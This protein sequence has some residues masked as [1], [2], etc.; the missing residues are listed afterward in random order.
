[1]T[2]F[3]VS[4]VRDEADIIAETV[5][6]MLR[7]VD[8]VIVADNGSVDGTR[9]ILADLGVTVV[10]DP[11]VG[12]Y[13]S[14]KMTG[15]AHLAASK[16]ADWVVPFDA[17]EWWYSPFGR[18]ADVLTATAAFVAEAA[19]YDHVATAHDPDGTPVARMGWRRRQPAELPKVAVRCRPDLV[20]HQGNHGAHYD[21][22]TAAVPGLLV[23]RHF[24][25]RTTDQF[26]AKA[27]NGAQAYRATDLPETE[28]AHWR[29]YGDLLEAE[30]AEGL[31]GVFRQWFWSS[32][33]DEDPSLIFD[34]VGR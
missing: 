22:P 8:E 11:E 23:V 10:G 17:D 5:G 27:R 34:P 29:A 12:Y 20:V 6:H 33:P 26:V 19:L 21:G 4:M 16:G 30:G 1:M 13:Q 18:I 24:P 7:Q 28:G 15:L 25:Y 14:A 3:A 9:D 2:V 31:A 32:L